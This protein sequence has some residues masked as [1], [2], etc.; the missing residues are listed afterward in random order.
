M[1]NEVRLIDATPLIAD[2]W[3][4]EK[5]GVSNCDIG[6]KSLADVPTIDPETLRPKG[7]WVPSESDFD[8]DDTLFD[9]EDW[10]D[11]KCTACNNDICYEDPQ[12][13]QWLPKFCPNC[14]AKMEG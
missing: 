13:R 7:M 5:H 8:D 10:C 4:L 3:V 12:E 6:R 2:G 14:G 11:W 1:A 9:V